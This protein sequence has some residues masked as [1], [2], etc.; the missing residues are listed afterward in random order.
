MSTTIETQ[1]VQGWVRH[2]FKCPFN[3]L[4]QP[5]LA[6]S[7]DHTMSSNE[8]ENQDS[9][10]Q[11]RP[12]ARIDK[13]PEEEEITHSPKQPRCRTRYRPELPLHMQSTSQS[14]PF[15][16]TPLKPEV[17]EAKVEA[18]TELWKRETEIVATQETTKVEDIEQDDMPPPPPPEVLEESLKDEKSADLDLFYKKAPVPSDDSD[19]AETPETPEIPE[20]G[21]L[22]LESFHPSHKPPEEVKKQVDEDLPKGNI[23]EKLAALQRPPPTIDA[24]K[25]KSEQINRP[26][27]KKAEKSDVDCFW[28]ALKSDMKR[29]KMYVGDCDF[30]DVLSEDEEIMGVPYGAPT[31]PSSG[32][33]PPPPPLLL[34]PRPSIPG[35]GAPPPPPPPGAPPPSGAPPAPPG[36]PGG[37]PPPPPGTIN[38][39]GKWKEGVKKIKN[40]R[41]FWSEV[42]PKG[43]SDSIWNKI[44][45]EFKAPENFYSK[46]DELFEVKTKE[47]KLKDRSNGRSEK[48]NE[49]VVLDQKRSN[50]INIA[51]R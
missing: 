17:I 31:F 27:P 39:Q 46:L 10:D 11:H 26:E 22:D 24:S 33:P 8:S 5:N 12:S 37:A 29:E 30:S 7:S 2:F 34:P 14:D 1:S 9:I 41:L 20:P 15:F 4:I 25:P 3:R 19:R 36:P 21:K 23:K 51:L 40:I 43:T 18:E 49:I 16:E 13:P 48:V 42:K 32:G 50:A 28:D 45:S 38:T 35:M 6:Y 47:T 44:G